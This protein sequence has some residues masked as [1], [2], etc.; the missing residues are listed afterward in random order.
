[1]YLKDAIC[2]VPISKR[3]SAI[4]LRLF[5]V[6]KFAFAGSTHS[7]IASKVSTL[8]QSFTMDAIETEGRRVSTHTEKVELANDDSNEGEV[9][10]V[11]KRREGIKTMRRRRKRTQLVNLFRDSG[12]SGWFGFGT[13]RT[14]RIGTIW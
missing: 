14:G 12:I 3:H 7:I 11:P 4:H 13:I 5:A 6:S 2:H 8:L 10:L 9:V 1:M